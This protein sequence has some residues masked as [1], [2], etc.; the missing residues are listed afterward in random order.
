MERSA[1]RVENT[2]ERFER[3][4]KVKIKELANKLTLTNYIRHVVTDEAFRI[5]NL[6]KYK[7]SNKFT[8]HSPIIK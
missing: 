1:E 6:R 4:G 8:I 2:N 3:T 5:N 7:R